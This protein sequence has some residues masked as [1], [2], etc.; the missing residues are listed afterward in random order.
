MLIFLIGF[1]GSGKSHLGKEL[2]SLM[3][4]KFMDT[5]DLTEVREK[6]KIT[7]IFEKKGEHYFREAERKTLKKILSE[8]KTVVAVGGGLPCYFDNMEEMNKQGVT[9]YLEAS[10]GFLFH[11]LFNEKE[12]RP[13]ISKLNS[14]EL[15]DFIIEKLHQRKDFY[16]QA[17]IKVEAET[18]TAE[19]LKKKVMSYKL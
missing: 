10:A 19:K 4:Y 9:I 8:K 7:T 11:R 14:V 3:K 5:D 17:A 15:M 13:L 12:K 18:V 16:E 6:R 1:M 2:A